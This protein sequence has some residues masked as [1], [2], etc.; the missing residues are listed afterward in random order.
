MRNKI[1]T[2]FIANRGE[3]ALRIIRT[4]KKLG[5]KTALGVSDADANS[6]G[7][8][9]ADIVVRLGPAPSSQSYLNIAKVVAA[10]KEAGADAV[11]PGYGFLSERADFARAC[12][13]AGLVFV[14]PSADAIAAMGDKAEAK[15]RMIEAGV[16]C[17][18]GYQGV[19]QSDAT[20][21]A[22]AEKTGFPV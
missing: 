10:A 5:L 19:D 17:V 1:N 8:A 3:I 22:E 2:L 20:L 9:E 21:I 6:R 16:P 11:H 12:A 18:P 4:A 13:E 7:A 14:G 15:R